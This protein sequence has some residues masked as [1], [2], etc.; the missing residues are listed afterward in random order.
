MLKPIITVAHSLWQIARAPMV[1]PITFG[2]LQGTPARLMAKVAPLLV[3]FFLEIAANR[4]L[5]LNTRDRALEFFVWM[6]KQSVRRAGSV[7][8]GIGGMSSE[9]DRRL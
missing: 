3:Q 2:L 7:L 6:S 4:T 8:V 5:E 1:L 9:V